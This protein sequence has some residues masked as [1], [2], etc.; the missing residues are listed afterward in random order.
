MCYTI[1][2]NESMVNSEENV[3]NEML[4]TN[5]IND[6]IPKLTCFFLLHMHVIKRFAFHFLSPRT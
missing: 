6:L 1:V 4:N 3:A 2:S 5:Y